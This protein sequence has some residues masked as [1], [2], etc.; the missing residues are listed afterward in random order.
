MRVFLFAFLA[1]KWQLRV[2]DQ[3]WVT[4]KDI[5]PNSVLRYGYRAG[6]LAEQ[7]N[8]QAT[9]NFHLNPLL[10]LRIQSA[11][12]HASSLRGASVVRGR[13]NTLRTGD[14]DLRF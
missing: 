13:F 10:S 6:Y 3:T 8:P 5:Y 14:A 9:L 11:Y 7:N 4:R 1:V 2:K 12:F